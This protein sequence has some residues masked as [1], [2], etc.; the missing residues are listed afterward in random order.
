MSALPPASARY[1]VKFVARATR[2]HELEHWVRMHPKGFA[3]AFPPRVVNNVYFDTPDLFTFRENLTGAS[4]RAKV[5]LRWYGEDPRPGV[6]TLEV[7]RRRNQLGWKH[8]FPAGDLDFTKLSW[9]EIRRR[10]RSVLTPEGRPWLDAFPEP[11]LV[12]CYERAYFLSRDGSVRVTLDRRQ[13]VFDQRQRPHPDLRRRA[14]LP[15]TLVLEVKFGRADREAGASV[16]RGIPIRVSRNSK[17]VIGVR[18]I[19]G[20]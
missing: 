11:V 12:N 14:N 10:V 1:E 9:K 16:L 8:T 20:P 6:T 15:D 19:A 17:Y 18:A 7:K 5:R 13:A 3:R 2:F 4:A